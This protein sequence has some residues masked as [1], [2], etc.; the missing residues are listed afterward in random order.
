MKIRTV[1]NLERYLVSKK[2]KLSHQLLAAEMKEVLRVNPRFL[3]Y[4]NEWI[5]VIYKGETL[6]YNSLGEK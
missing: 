1:D 4:A 2:T 5:A 6:Q 3:T